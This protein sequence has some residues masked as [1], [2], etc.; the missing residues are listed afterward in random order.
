MAWPILK[1]FKVEPDAYHWRITKEVW[2]AINCMVEKFHDTEILL[3]VGGNLT[4]RTN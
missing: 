4:A 2:S 3:G 1:I